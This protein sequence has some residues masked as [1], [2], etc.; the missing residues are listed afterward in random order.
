MICRFSRCISPAGGPDAS[1]SSFFFRR[2][3]CVRAFARCCRRFESRFADRRFG[4]YQSVSFGTSRRSPERRPP[5]SRE[6]TRE[7]SGAAQAQP[8]RY[9]RYAGIACV[10]GQ[11]RAAAFD[12]R[13][14]RSRAVG[15]RTARAAPERTS[16]GRRAAARRCT[17]LLHRRAE[18]IPLRARRVEP[19]QFG[20]AATAA[21][22]VVLRQRC[23]LALRGYGRRGDVAVGLQYREVMGAV[24]G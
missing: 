7:G 6:T 17:A 21:A 24:V 23:A 14:P 5:G 12:G 20:C 22:C 11:A 8:V 1:S 13:Q 19:V 18:S 9:A 2:H 3:H 10:G 15:D 4:Q 16:V